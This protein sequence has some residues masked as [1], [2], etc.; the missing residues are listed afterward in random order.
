LA[1][2]G[3]V[4]TAAAADADDDDDDDE[5]ESDDDRRGARLG[6]LAQ[7][8]ARAR[9]LEEDA[10][11]EASPERAAGARA[12]E[13]ARVRTLP[14][15][16]K[17]L[18]VERE[19]E[20]L[21]CAPSEGYVRLEV[22]R[23][24][25]LEDSVQQLLA[26]DPTALRQW[27]RVQFADEPGI[28]V[29]GLEREWFEL[30]AQ[31][32]FDP[33]VGVFKQALGDG[34]MCFEPSGS[35]P[36]K[37]GGHPRSRELYEFTGRLLAKALVER[38]PVG[39][40]LSLP[41]YKQLVGGV[42]EFEDLECLDPDLCRNL[43]WLV[44]FSGVESLDLDFTVATPRSCPFGGAADGAE[45]ASD[46]EERDVDC[47]TYD[48]VRRAADGNRDATVVVRSLVAG[49]ADVRVDDANK[50]DYVRRLWRH[51]VLEAGKDAM[52][53][54]AR[55]VYSVLPP[56]LLSVLDANELELLLCGSPV[57]DV[58][59]WA[60]NT[61]YAGEYRRRGARHAVIAWWWKAVRALEDHDRHKLL[62]FCTGSARVPCHGFRA[63]QRND[64][65]YQLFCI[66]SL[67]RTELRFP[68]AHTCFNRIDLPMYASYAELEA[69]LRV[70]L[71]ME[72]TG[73][74][75]D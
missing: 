11:A 36:A 3:A 67:P 27:M 75:M 63:L 10:D 30:A 43:D 20:K 35:L 31:A 24:C 74:T 28:D 45:D 19:L 7:R 51:H 44:N 32:V 6:A 1:A 17:H 18:W 56:D 73:F 14:F 47:L 66:Q 16:E 55:G 54:L 72:A 64:G 49:G 52:W 69:S 50:R 62:M 53:H 40:P 2:F 29:G 68:R 34:G 9:I 65:K 60:A 70:V 46:D 12:E 25:L 61:E 26:L 13:L 22:R 58:D 59:D 21:R 71:C 38:I 33:A 5:E 42:L 48:C 57:V 23:S 8:A 39:A 37:L 41:L 4:E 15:R